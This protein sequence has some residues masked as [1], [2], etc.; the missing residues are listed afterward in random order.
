MP[1]TRSTVAHMIERFTPPQGWATAA[2]EVF[3]IDLWRIPFVIVSA[4]LIYVAFLVL[5]R[6]FGIRILGTMS[7]FDAVVIIMFGAVAGR[8]ILGHPPT[9]MVGVIGLATLM[10][11]EAIFGAVQHTFGFRRAVSARPRIVM[12]H[13]KMIPHAM[14]RAHITEANLYVAIREAGIATPDLVQCVILEAT[15]RLS[16]IQEG[17]P[18]DPRLLENVEGREFVLN[19][20]GQ[21]AD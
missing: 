16:V 1:N 10:V 3:G 21:D 2:G 5:V 9:V 19:T 14:R 18:I 4:V 8:V 13:G 20:P 7:S 6:I 17:T 11:M 12:A 15:G